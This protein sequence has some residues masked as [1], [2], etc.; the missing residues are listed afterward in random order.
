M[1]IGILTNYS[2]DQVGGAEEALD[3]LATHWH[4]NGYS[5][6]LF[7]PRPKRLEDR[8]RPWSPEYPHVALAPPISTKFF[9]KR[10]LRPLRSAHAD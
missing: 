2:L 6:R 8:K 3:R 9:L 1:R 5:V 10:Y 4:R 7:C